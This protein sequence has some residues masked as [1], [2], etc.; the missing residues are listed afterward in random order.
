[1]VTATIGD[2]FGASSVARALSIATLLFAV[3]QTAGPVAA[4]AMAGP[5][6]IFTHAYLVAALVAAGAALFALTLPAKRRN[7]HDGC[8]PPTC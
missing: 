8:R 2:H 7:A 3:G 5:K 1:V 4:G 6:G